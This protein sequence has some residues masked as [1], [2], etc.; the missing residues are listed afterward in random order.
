VESTHLITGKKIHA[1]YGD[2]AN[3]QGRVAGENAVAGDTVSFPGTLQTGVCK[4]FDYA[5]GSTGLSED[6]ARA[7]GYQALTT[8]INASP[9]KPGYMQGLLLVTK[10]VADNRT[11]RILGA[12]C[13]GPGDVSKQLAIWAMAIRGRLTVEDMVNADLPYA[14]PFSLALDHSIA[15]AHILQNKFKG[16]MTGLSAVEVK[17]KLD[18]GETPFLLDARGPDEYEELRLGVGEHLIPL[19]ALRSRLHELPAAKDSEIICYC[20]VSLRGYEAARVLEGRGWKNVK[21]MEGGLAAWP[22]ARER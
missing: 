4:V 13:V 5:A 20:K 6:S 2:L 3:L 8:C 16:R 7:S 11:G 17:R 1:P 19:G 15:T 10:L 21:V 18:A 14:P 12:Q 22:Y 9:D